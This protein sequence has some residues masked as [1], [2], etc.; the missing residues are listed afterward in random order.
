[1]I[2]FEVMDENLIVDS[3][4]GG[5]KVMIGSLCKNNATQDWFEIYHEKK[6]AGRILIRSEFADENGVLQK[7]TKE[8]IKAKNIQAKKERG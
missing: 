3:K 6:P 8:T 1:M 5:L 7:S 2:H 4:I